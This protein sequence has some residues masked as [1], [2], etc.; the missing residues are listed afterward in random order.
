M[1][2]EL[3]CKECGAPRDIGRRLCRQCNRIR[4]LKKARST[5]RYMWNNVCVA[6]RNDFKAWR[7]DSRLC[8]QC[9]IDLIAVRRSHNVANGYVKDSNGKSN[10]H[11]T[12]AGELIGRKLTFNEV[13]HHVDCNHLNNSLDNLMIMTRSAHSRLHQYLDEQQLITE[14]STDDNLKNSW[15]DLIVPT[16]ITWLETTNTKVIR[17][18]ENYQTPPEPLAFNPLRDKV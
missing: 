11:C 14:K 9:Q 7:K 6:C 15:K 13:V 4:L 3:V 2:K 10:F 17:L 8:K 18:S 16:T 1:E 12:L 5:P